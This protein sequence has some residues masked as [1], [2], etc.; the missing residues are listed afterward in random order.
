MEVKG[1][2]V[3]IEEL[4]LLVNKCTVFHVQ[5]K[6]RVGTGDTGYLSFKGTGEPLS[7]D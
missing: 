7:V 2:M 5:I 6:K 1:V 3:I 4:D